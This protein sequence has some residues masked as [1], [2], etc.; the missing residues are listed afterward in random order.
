MITILY[1][2]ICLWARVFGV[3]FLN[4]D[5]AIALLSTEAIVFIAYTYYTGAI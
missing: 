1:L 2:C 5:L 3:D 4:G